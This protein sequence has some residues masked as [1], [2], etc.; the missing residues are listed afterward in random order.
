MCV[1]VRARVYIKP[2]ECMK[3]LHTYSFAGRAYRGKATIDGGRA[4]VNILMCVTQYAY[5][6][7]VCTALY[8]RRPLRRCDRFPVPSLPPAGHSFSCFS[9]VLLCACPS[10][11]LTLSLSIYL[12]LVLSTPFSAT[13]CNISRS[14]IGLVR[15]NY[16]NVAV[17]GACLLLL[18]ARIGLARRVYNNNN[19]I[20]YLW[21]DL[22]IGIL[23]DPRITSRIKYN[24]HSA[25]IPV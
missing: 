17:R 22:S 18:Y 9:L 25:Y 10:L 7:I 20:I 24:I 8:T 11:S 14:R 1:C 5:I 3:G 12:S 4:F 13:E 15:L 16:P 23:F 6:Y 21:R 2:S 19:N